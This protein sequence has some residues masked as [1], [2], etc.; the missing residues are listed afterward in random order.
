MLSN[1]LHE[2]WLHFGCVSPRGVVIKT[3][4]ETSPCLLE[5]CC[6]VQ[7]YS[8]ALCGCKS[9]GGVTF[10]TGFFFCR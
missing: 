8:C 3:G 10:C 2:V 6:T 7:S 1:N 4:V 5:G 9:L